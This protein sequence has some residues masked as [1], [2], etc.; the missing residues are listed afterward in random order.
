MKNFVEKAMKDDVSSML[1]KRASL[2]AEV[3]ALD[4]Q[5]AEMKEVQRGAQI[6]EVRGLISRY[7]L[8]MKEVFPSAQ[9]GKRKP[10]AD[11][12]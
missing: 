9:T 10:A 1:E 5:I 2:E 4:Q 8:A 12:G 11:K 6:N 3:R 7:G